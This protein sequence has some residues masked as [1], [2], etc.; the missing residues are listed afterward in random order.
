[1]A[2]PALREV[3]R[4]RDRTPLVLAIPAVVATLFLVLPLVTA[5]WVA[6][7][8]GIYFAYAVFAVSLGFLW[9]HAGMLSLGHAVYFGLGAYAMSVV[10]LGMV[11]GLLD[12]KSTWLGLVAAVVVP[13]L[14][15]HEMERELKQKAI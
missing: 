4:S 14:D 2:S 8:F 7:D 9:G 6:G 5:D 12:L 1:M 15:A 11:P 3:G 10:T 13:G